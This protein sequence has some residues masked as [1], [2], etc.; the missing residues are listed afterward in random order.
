MGMNNAQA[1]SLAPAKVKK[2]G[3]AKKDG[4][5]GQRKGGSKNARPAGQAG[6][7]KENN[8]G[9]QEAGILLVLKKLK[10]TWPGS[11]T[12][13]GTPTNVRGA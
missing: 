3:L 6:A 13:D 10:A 5:G 1:D 11:R 8:T 9:A 12:V 2:W 7:W 4:T